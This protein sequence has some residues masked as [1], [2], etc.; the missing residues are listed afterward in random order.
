MSKHL[1]WK[2]SYSYYTNAAAITEFFFNSLIDQVLL[3][4]TNIVDT[5]SNLSMAVSVTTTIDDQNEENY[6]VVVELITNASA[7]F[8]AKNL[9]LPDQESVSEYLSRW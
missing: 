7:M 5:I 3:N 4:E 2:S 8:I 1:N 6:A 9:N